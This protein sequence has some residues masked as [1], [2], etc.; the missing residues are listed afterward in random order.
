M[1]TRHILTGASHLVPL[2]QGNLSNMCGL[3]SVLNAIQLAVY[4]RRLTKPEL[5]R[6]YRLAIKHLSRRKQLQG[7]LGI[8]MGY[9]L[10]TELRD[11]LIAHANSCY[12]FS[13]KPTF[14]LSGTATTDRKRALRK[15]TKALRRGR[16]VLAHFGGALEHYSVVCGYADQ[17][18]FLF[19]SSGLNWVQADN[20]G[21][22]EQ[23]RRRH[24]ILAEY[25]FTL[26][27]DW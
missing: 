24:Q 13:L 7:V 27:E 10:W 14:T 6:L 4:P 3:Y 2:Q 16:P 20:V 26:V 1:T 21:L 19:D 17:K 15:I 12:G 9:Q 18:L 23:S 22:G 5:Q 25:T 8:G 11:V